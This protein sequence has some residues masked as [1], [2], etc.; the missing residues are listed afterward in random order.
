MLSDINKNLLCKDAIIPL[1]DSADMGSP[2]PDLTD[3]KEEFDYPGQRE[4]QT[5]VKSMFIVDTGFNPSLSFNETFPVE[6]AKK[7]VRSH[8]IKL[9]Q[10]LRELEHK[11]LIS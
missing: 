5:I 10:K 4:E 3:S 7:N 8:G 2:L 1:P 11:M 6:R 9:L